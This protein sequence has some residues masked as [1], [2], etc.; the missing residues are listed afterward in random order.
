MTEIFSFILLFL[1]PFT[2]VPFGVTQFENPKVVLAEGLIILLLLS[3]LFQTGSILDLGRKQ[4][5]IY[6]LIF[7]VTIFDLI[8]L[9]TSV[10][11]F[12]NAFRLQGIFLLWLLLLFSFIVTHVSLSKAP[13]WVFAFLLYVQIGLSLFLPINESGRYVGTFGEPNALGGFALF[14]W[15]FAW[16]AVKEENVKSKIGKT[17]LIV[18]VITILYLSGSRS[19]AIGFLVQMLFLVIQK[20]GFNI[21]KA[22]VVCLIA[23]VLSLSF[24]FFEKKPY[25]NRVEIWS[26]AVS[27]GL[28]RPILGH[29]FGNTEIALQKAAKKLKLPIE[30]VYFDS[31]HNIFLDWWVQGGIIGLGLLLTLVFISIKNFVIYQHKR[32]LVLTF[33]LLSVLV[34]N[35]ASVAGLLAFWWVIGRGFEHNVG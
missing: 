17:L 8:F 9:N 7:A 26:S 18:G 20:L 10:S 19:A 12:G 27:A 1:L 13:W 29:G 6:L 32:E 28:E 14:V 34:F 30:D 35:P 15:P 4:I 3:R 31:A 2:V 16:F 23:I 21:K 25:E 24:P 11:F 22:A 33:G 5:V